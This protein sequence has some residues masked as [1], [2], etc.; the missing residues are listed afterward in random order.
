MTTLTDFVNEE[1]AH[2]RSARVNGDQQH[3]WSALERAHILS[4]PDAMLHTKVHLDMLLYGVCLSDWR[5]VLGQIVRLAVAGIGSWLG[6]A[7]IGNT[8]RSHVPIMA[9]LPVPPDLAE[10]LAQA[11]RF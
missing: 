6:K 8:G 9:V 1:L 3:A 10:K 11:K 5:E 2:F 7:P 4:Q